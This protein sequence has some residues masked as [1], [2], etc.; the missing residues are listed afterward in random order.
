MSSF[1]EEP[2]RAEA[3]TEVLESV[4]EVGN[5]GDRWFLALARGLGRV[6]RLVA[7]GGAL[8]KGTGRSAARRTKEAGSEPVD[9]VRSELKR[10]LERMSFSPPVKP[11]TDLARRE[12]YLL[13]KLG[14]WTLQYDGRLAE[15]A[16]NPT[17]HDLIGEL[18]FVRES[19]E[20]RKHQAAAIEEGLEDAVPPAQRG[21]PV[22]EPEALGPIVRPASGN[23][24]EDE[25]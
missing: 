1:D 25:S 6:A 19:M 4:R 11:E 2:L 20:V 14:E 13:A 3:G 10:D 21:E 17:Y 8:V 18:R 9:D 22:E 12:S 16:E 7:R 24:R 23:E 15:L 5:T